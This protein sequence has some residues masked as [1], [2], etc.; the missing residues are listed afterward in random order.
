MK[1]KI[2]DLAIILASVLAFVTLL[3][4]CFGLSSNNDSDMEER[5]LLARLVYLEA[6]TCSPECQ[7]AMASVVLNMVETG[8][9]GNSIEE[10]IFYP[11]AFSPAYLIKD[12]TPNQAAYDAVDYVLTYGSQLPKE[13]RYFRADYDFDWEGYA[14]HTVIDN[15]YFGYFTNGNH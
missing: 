9:W 15:V 14:N 5:E 6:G 12:C 13:V 7:R 2:F 3:G 11:N 8:Y 1:E 4:V 10:V